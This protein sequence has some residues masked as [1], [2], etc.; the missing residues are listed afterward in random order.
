M[1]KIAGLVLL[2]LMAGGGFAQIPDGYYD[3]TEGLSGVDLKL[4]LH[5]IIEDHTELEYDNGGIEYIT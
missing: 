5:T 1:K 2:I 4:K 3:G